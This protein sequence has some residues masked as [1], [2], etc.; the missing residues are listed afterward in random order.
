MSRLNWFQNTTVPTVDFLNPVI[1]DGAP[2]T[3]TAAAPACSLT[4]YLSDLDST[5][6]N[7]AATLAD[8]LVDG[9]VK[10]VVASVVANTTT[11]TI[12][13]PVSASLDV[14][15]FTV[16]GDTV[17]LIWNAENGYWRIYQL[18]DTDRDV[19]TPTVA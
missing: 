5:S 9:Q 16:I 3:L 8:G 17:D 18:I 2:E 4:C 10:R 6:N 14:V 15:T 11:L 7:V 13:S 12:A 19:D 1:P